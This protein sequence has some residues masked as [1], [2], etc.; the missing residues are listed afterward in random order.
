MRRLLLPLLLSLPIFGLAKT[1]GSSFS[2]VDRIKFRAIAK[3]MN[4][5]SN[6]GQ[7]SEFFVPSLHKK[8]QKQCRNKT[9]TWKSLK[10]PLVEF[11][12]TS[13]IFKFNSTQIVVEMKE[14]KQS[15]LRVNGI[16]FVYSKNRSFTHQID[17]LAQQVLRK[18]QS[19][20][21]SVWFHNHFISKAHAAAF[22]PP[23]IWVALGAAGATTANLVLPDLYTN[24]D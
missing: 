16:L 1:S 3:H 9:I 7:L 11:K 2:D 12:D 13:L 6:L 22:I 18:I 23:A 17:F 14:Y 8:D 20:G 5:F 10:A 21:K 19:K 15:R 4:S 24:K